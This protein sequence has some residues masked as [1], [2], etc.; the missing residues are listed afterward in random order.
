LLTLCI[1]RWRTPFTDA[2]AD[3]HDD[4]EDV[5]EAQAPYQATVEDADEDDYDDG[6]GNGNVEDD[7]MIDSEATLVIRNVAVSTFG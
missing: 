2:Y 5:A 4:T 7:G 1:C 3:Y 6:N